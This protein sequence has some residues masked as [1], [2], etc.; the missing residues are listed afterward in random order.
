M[1]SRYVAAKLF[2]VLAAL[3]VL[4]GA[5]LYRRYVIGAGLPSRNTGS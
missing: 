5:V 3:F 4:V 1:N 2:L